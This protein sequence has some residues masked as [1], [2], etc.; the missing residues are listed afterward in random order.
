MC[1]I[2][3]NA[4]RA[5][6]PKQMTDEQISNVL[7]ALALHISDRLRQTVDIAAEHGSTA[8]SAIVVIAQYPGESIEFLSRIL[9]LSHSATVRL[10]DRLIDSGLVSKGP[11]SDARAV[12]LTCTSSGAKRARSILRAR[13]KVLQ[14][15]V[16]VLSDVDKRHLEVILRKLPWTGVQS[17]EAAIHTCRLCDYDRCDLKGNCPVTIARLLASSPDDTAASN[18]R[19]NGY[20]PADPDASSTP[21]NRLR[22]H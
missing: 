17:R 16:S 5:D 19:Q 10:V 6:R 14:P 12:A 11:A 22:K 7:G 20:D 3:K 2:H 9:N 21:R 13:Q 8:P 4:E 15:L 18:I 1:V